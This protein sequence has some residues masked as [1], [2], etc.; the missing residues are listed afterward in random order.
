MRIGQAAAAT[1]I[2][3][4]TIRFYEASGVLPEPARTASGYRDYGE[5]DLRRLRFVR[6]ARDLGL[7]L[8]DI[9]EM[10]AIDLAG[11]APCGYVRGLLERH[12]EEIDRR[13]RELEAL[14]A[15]L[16]D[17]ARRASLL[18]DRAGECVCHILEGATS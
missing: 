12:T 17:L 9:R 6:R 7:A 4:A 15:E 8:D 16:D 1:G 18:G 13:I 3:P 5:D 11:E 2:D 14:R 10:L